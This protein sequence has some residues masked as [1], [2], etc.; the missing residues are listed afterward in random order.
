[1]TVEF[2]LDGHAFV[3]LD[4]GPLFTFNEAISFGVDCK[5]QDEVDYYWSR[6]SDGGKTGQCG[7]LGDRF[8][9]AWQIVSTALTQLLGDPDREKAQRVMTAMLAMTKPDVAAIEKAA[10]QWRGNCSTHRGNADEFPTVRPSYRVTPAADETKGSACS[11][12]SPV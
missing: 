12:V 2:E 8:G 5:D 9:V 11:L 10:A 1:M 6:L 7:W 3:A 4:G